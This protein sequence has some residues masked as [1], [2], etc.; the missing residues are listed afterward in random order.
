[1]LLD[2]AAVRY[3]YVLFGAREED[4]MESLIT[5]TGEIWVKPQPGETEDS[6]FT[7]FATSISKATQDILEARVDS[8][9]QTID[10][11]GRALDDE[12]LNDLLAEVAR[13][14]PHTEGRALLNRVQRHMKRTTGFP[15]WFLDRLDEGSRRAFHKATRK[16][17]IKRDEA[18]LTEKRLQATYAAGLGKQWDVFI[19]HASEDKNEF[20]RPLADALSKSGLNIWYDE[21]S[22]Q[23][24]DSLRRKIDEGLSNSRYGIVILSHQFFAKQWPQ[25]ELDG[26][27]GKE[28][29]GVKVILPIWHRISAKEV[30][31]YSPIL[32]GRFALRSDQGMDII[33]AKLRD[34]MGLG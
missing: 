10:K 21:H 29:A 17:L 30:L 12:L 7:R 14:I 16:L 3:A 23:V 31:Q 34:A 9:L 5:E 2:D 24:G 28:I 13:M 11:V 26:L 4:I 1:M 27:F 32:A 6:L 20:V 22:L 33:V 15:V 8:F 18:A 19:S 25:Q